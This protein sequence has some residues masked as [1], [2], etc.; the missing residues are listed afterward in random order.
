MLIAI[1]AGGKGSRFIKFSKKP[2]LLIKFKDYTLLDN[3]INQCMN[4]NLKK[5]FLFL[6]FG[7]DKIIQYLKYNKIKVNYVLES[8]PLGTGGALKIIENKEDKNILVIMGDI[9]AN[10]NFK[11]FITF[12]K[13]K[14]SDITFFAHPNNHPYDSDLIAT[15]EDSR[16]IRFYSKNRKKRLYVRNLAS[17]GIYIVKTKLLKLLKKKN[18]EFLLI[19]HV[20]M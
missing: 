13:S 3:Y 9:L 2:K 4:F 10:I 18:I 15:D 17:A 14:K 12:H 6:G 5:I 20:S 7:S 1:L 11:K 19:I 16:V 8:K